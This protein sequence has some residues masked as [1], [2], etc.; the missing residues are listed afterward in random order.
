MRT[1]QQRGYID[2]TG[3]DVGPGQASLFGTTD[4]FLER[5]GLNSIDELPSLGDLIP[6][7]DV[8]EL[9]EQSLIGLPEFD[10]TAPIEADRQEQDTTPGPADSEND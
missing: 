4:L 8:V 5:L 7:A 1:L 10:E 2:E 6:G 9:L 3:R